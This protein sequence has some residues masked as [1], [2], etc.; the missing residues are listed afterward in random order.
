MNN[1]TRKQQRRCYNHWTG[2]VACLR[3]TW[4]WI[5]SQN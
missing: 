1:Q 2:K 5:P 4:N 3:H